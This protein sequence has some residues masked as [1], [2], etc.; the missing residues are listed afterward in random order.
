[1]NTKK[2]V[3]EG[4]TSTAKAFARFLPFTIFAGAVGMFFIIMGIMATQ[5]DMRSA[6]ILGTYISGDDMSAISTIALFLI[7]IFFA[8]LGAAAPFLSIYEV[9]K[10][11]IKVYEDRVSGVHIDGVGQQSQYLPFEFTYDKIE[12]VSADKTKLYIQITGRTIKC[13]AFNAD[14]VASAIS[15]RLIRS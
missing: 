6:Y 12:S 9:K 7:G 5:S 13:R 3:L 11:F 2:L 4:D 15:V 14:E 10:C 1:M 8:G